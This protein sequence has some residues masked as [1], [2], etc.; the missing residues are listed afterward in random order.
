MPIYSNKALITTNLRPVTS[1]F[2]LTNANLPLFCYILGRFW[3]GFCRFLWSAFVS[4]VV[5]SQGLRTTNLN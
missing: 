2:T 4:Y 1:T 5:D 3:A